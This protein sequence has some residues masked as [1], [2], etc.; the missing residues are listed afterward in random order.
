MRIISWNINGIAS[1]FEELRQL[2]GSYRPDIVC[3]QKVRC[4]KQRNLFAID[5]YRILYEPCD[6]GSWSG[7]VVYVRIPNESRDPKSA[8]YP[9]RLPTPELSR[10]GHLQVYECRD[11]ILINAYVPF[12]NFAIEGAVD[13]RKQWDTAFR[14]FTRDLSRRK[15][16]VICGDLNVVHTIRDSC[17]I[18]L[19]QNR[20]NFTGWERENF[21]LLMADCSLA[22]AFRIF[23]PEE[24]AATFYGAYRQTGIGNRLDYFLVS[25]SL[26][27]L[28]SSSEILSD[29]GSGQSVPIL[30]DLDPVPLCQSE[31]LP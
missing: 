24:Q 10:D 11:F 28:L 6:S 27:P 1:R 2:I 30:L 18:R 26:L 13:G 19:E 22:D 31:L 4:N 3:L 16:V 29:F 23:H 20:P 12:A 8:S 21:N 25:R 9:Q 15:P 17:E 14:L 7:V 5:G